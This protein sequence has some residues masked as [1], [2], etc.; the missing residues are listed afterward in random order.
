MATARE[1]VV[2]LLLNAAGFKSE[3]RSAQGE[4]DKTS[5]AADK[6]AKAIDGVGASAAKTGNDL[7][8][9]TGGM[10]AFG[11][12][13][14]GVIGKIAGFAGIA[15]GVLTLKGV[16]TDYLATAE[17]IDKT[18]QKL[19]MGV[20]EWQGWRHAAIESGADA[21]SLGDVFASLDGNMKELAQ[22]G[23]G[24]LKEVMTGMGVK[25]TDA[26]GR[27]VSL[28]EGILR[29]AD[30]T[31]KMDKQKAASLLN[32][33]GLDENSV[34]MLRQGRK[35]L[36]ELVKAGKENAAYSQKDIEVTRK[37]QAA[38]L[39]LQSTFESL[40][41]KI[42]HSI[43]PAMGDMIETLSSV[44]KWFHDNESSATV[45]FAA[46]AAVIAMAV[47]PSLWAMATAAWA[48]IAPFAP[49]IALV[50]GL[51]FIVEDLVV[52]IEGGESALADFW[53]MFGTGE[54]VG[55]RLKII[56]EGIKETFSGLMAL[57]GGV[58]QLLGAIFTGG[59]L[60]SYKDAV[61]AISAALSN[62]GKIA[63]SVLGYIKNKLKNI[64]PGWAMDLLG[65]SNDS[66]ADPNGSTPSP[67]ASAN[68]DPNGSTPPLSASAAAATPRVS[69]G[70]AQRP[71]GIVD[72]S[73]KVESTT[74]IQQLTVQSQATDA[75]G[76][77]RDITESLPNRVAQADGAY[78]V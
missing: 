50:A 30:A 40:R 57:L 54:E 46:I 41:N 64:L 72:N 38:K 73:R 34:N 49:I 16:V 31:G 32:K 58:S 21:S 5:A 78:G 14:S 69:P 62:L 19:A 6:T 55:N 59:Q 26:K 77:A 10:Q 75:N 70:E 23:S 15:G 66:N 67:S 24:P 39:S 52:Y 25:F 53:S 12:S 74:T 28:Q 20:D 61:A 76:I 27:A 29:L 8:G 45:Y 71:A 68:A 48:A 33:I 18:S 22:S 36:E 44:V 56:W 9:A 17:S 13:L 2:K 60:Y 43:A 35:G 47:T 63:E 3:V 42:R 65:W 1:L 37:V 7:K 4:M 11:T 51:A